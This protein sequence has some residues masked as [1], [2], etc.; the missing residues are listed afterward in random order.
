MLKGKMLGGLGFFLELVNTSLLQL[1]LFHTFNLRDGSLTVWEHA[2][3]LPC[4]VLV[5][6]NV[7]LS[8]FQSKM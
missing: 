3:D 7:T 2:D 6:L 1:L 5:F 8:L 4:H